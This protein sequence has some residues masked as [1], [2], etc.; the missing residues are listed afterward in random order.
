MEY[1]L[2]E[3]DEMPTELDC[4]SS[5]VYVYLNKNIHTESREDMNGETSTRYVFEQAKVT[6][7]EYIAMLHEEQEIT[8]DALQELI[9][10]LE[11]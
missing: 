1:R 8:N 5:D 6:K 9:I 4:T 2:C 3:S 10:G 11:V 7:N